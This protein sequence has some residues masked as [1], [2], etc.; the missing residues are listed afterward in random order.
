MKMQAMQVNR[1][2]DTQ[3]QSV[4]EREGGNR[5]EGEEQD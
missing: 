5:R 2:T 4:K 1:M 3:L